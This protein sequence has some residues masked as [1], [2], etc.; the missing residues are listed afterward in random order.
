MLPRLFP[1]SLG[2]V[3]MFL[4]LELSPNVSRMLLNS[5]LSSAASGIVNY[6]LNFGVLL[7]AEIFLVIV[8]GSICSIF[9]L[10]LGIGVLICVDLT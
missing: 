10:F 9:E 6:L 3:P 5:M 8:I 4:P 2:D 7:G 1:L